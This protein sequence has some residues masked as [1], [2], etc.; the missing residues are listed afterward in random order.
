MSVGFAAPIHGCDAP[1]R[2]HGPMS[3]GDVG[4]DHV[5]PAAVGKHRVHKW[6]GEIN[7]TARGLQHPLHEIAD[8]GG[9][10]DRRCELATPMPRDEDPARLV[11]PD[12]LHGGIVE[13]ALQHPEAGDVV[14]HVSCRGPGVSERRQCAGQAAL[15]IVGH[16]V[17][18]ELPHH[19]RL[20]DRVEAA[21]S[22]ELAYLVLDDGDRVHVTPVASAGG[23]SHRS[24]PTAPTRRGGRPRT[25]G[26]RRSGGR[27]RAHRPGAPRVTLMHKPPAGTKISLGGPR[28]LGLEASAGK[29]TPREAQDRASAASEQG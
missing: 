23:R 12:L 28:R 16:H 9:G 2:L 22:D 20:G 15:A 7:A 19:T 6:C 1:S 11:D 21:A 25:C 4:D 26:Q 14:E 29:D 27:T 13:I 17:F 18:D 24:L 10:E 5:Q 3:S 8:R